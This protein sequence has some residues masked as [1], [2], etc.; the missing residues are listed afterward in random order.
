MGMDSK[1]LSERLRQPGHDQTFRTSETNF[2]KAARACLSGDYDVIDKPRELSRCFSEEAETALGLQ[3]EAAIVS[4]K[5]QRR[6]FV[7]VKKQG[8]RGNAEERALKHHTVEFYKL[9]NRLYGYD[10]HPYVTIWCESLANLERYTRK[11]NY[12]FE[13]DQYF[14]WKDYDQDALCAYLN[15]RCR[16]W[17]D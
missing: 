8:D 14:L 11:A 12:L 2:L 4:K 13:K 10:Y 17:L 5:T 6:F 15:G 16:A 1:K 9:M 7:E 3:P